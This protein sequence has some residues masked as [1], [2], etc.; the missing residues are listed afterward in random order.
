[1]NKIRLMHCLDFPRCT[2]SMMRLKLSTR[3]I[4]IFSTKLLALRGRASLNV[5]SIHLQHLG[6][7]SFSIHVRNLLAAAQIVYS[8]PSRQVTPSK[9]ATFSI[10]SSSLFNRANTSARRKFL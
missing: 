7:P 5:L 3:V 4:Y 10:L 6:T 2:T 8:S 9:L 1:M